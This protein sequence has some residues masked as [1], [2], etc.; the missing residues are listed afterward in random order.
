MGLSGLSH[1]FLEVSSR[2][3]KKTL[4]SV[5]GHQSP[6]FNPHLELGDIDFS[7]L[8]KV[9]GELG[10]GVEISFH[11]DGDPLV[12]GRLA[13]ALD[14]F[15]GFVTSIVTHGQSLDRRA[16][17]IIGRATTVT[18]SVVQPD[19][20]WELQIESV[21]DFLAQRGDN[22]PMVNFKFV[23]F[24]PPERVVAYERLGL[25]ILRRLLHVPDGNYRYVRREPTKPESF[26]CLDMLHSPAVNWKAEVFVC[27]RFNPSHDG[28]LGSLHENTLDE[29]WNSPK[30][31][32]WLEAHKRGRRDQANPLCAKCLYWGVPSEA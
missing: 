18:V 12:Y 17:D 29:L 3:D 11:H 2:C 9:R 15:E 26:V 23:G 1:I 14:L 31:K 30:R 19:P 5:C 8:E 27:N 7:V 28:L 4:C 6:K 20:D 32:E 24:I 16:Q 25:P 22:S 13:D 21:K 10:T